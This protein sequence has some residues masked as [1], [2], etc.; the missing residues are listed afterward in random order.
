[1]KGSLT[2][3][4]ILAALVLVAAGCGTAQ[5][6]EAAGQG[7]IEIT[8]TD[9]SFQPE[10]I[11]LKAGQEVTLVLTNEGQIEHEFMAGREREEMGG[12][13]HDFFEGI[14]IQAS[15]EEYALE[16]VGEAEAGHG[17]AGH[18]EGHMGT[19][20]E[21]EP[22]GRAVLTFTVPAD[23]TGEWEVGCFLPGHYEAG[24]KA[25]LIIE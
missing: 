24:M 9:F 21:L 4:A 17:E 1:M 18:G 23:K 3:A 13:G 6:P 25:R 20:V 16:T 22:G 15:G 2:I 5:G 8:L 12:Y 10:A 14:E 11:R 19:E 7:P